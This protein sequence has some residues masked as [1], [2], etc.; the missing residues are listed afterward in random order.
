MVTFF[1][2]LFFTSFS[3]KLCTGLFKHIQDTLVICNLLT[4]FFSLDV[5]LATQWTLNAIS[6]AQQEVVLLQEGWKEM[7]INQMCVIIS[8]VESQKGINAVQ[9]CSAENQKGAI[10]LQSL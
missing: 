5:W 9:Q 4:H 8:S 1:S 3:N 7:D 2:F 6:G 10:T